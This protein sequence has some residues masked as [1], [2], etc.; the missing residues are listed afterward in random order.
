VWRLIPAVGLGQ[1]TGKPSRIGM[2]SYSITSSAR[3]RTE[4]GTSIPSALGALAFHTRNEP[5][6]RKQHSTSAISR[7]AMAL[8]A[9]RTA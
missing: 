1:L 4:D 5:P 2:G 8:E 7:S 6:Q 3:T 9:A